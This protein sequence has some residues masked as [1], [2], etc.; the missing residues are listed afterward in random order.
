MRLSPSFAASRL[1]RIAEGA[2][3]CVE[4]MQCLVLHIAAAVL[5]A[6]EVI[7]PE[8]DSEPLHSLA[9]ALLLDMCQQAA[10]ALTLLGEIPD[11]ITQA[12]ADLRVFI[13]DLLYRDHDRDFRTLAAFPPD[14]LRVFAVVVEV[15]FVVLALV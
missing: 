10:E 5:I 6:V 4:L 8:L 1:G 2:S 13:H 3:E 7:A 15:V 11:R 14:V 12:E 9:G